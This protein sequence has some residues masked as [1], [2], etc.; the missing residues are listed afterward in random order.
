MIEAHRKKTLFPALDRAY[1][2]NPRPVIELY[3]LEKD[4][5]ELNNIAD[6]PENAGLVRELKIALQEK[7]IL[8]YDFLPVPL[9]E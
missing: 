4:P 7:M 6:R 5:S 9:A 3:D 2:S 8:D 1:F